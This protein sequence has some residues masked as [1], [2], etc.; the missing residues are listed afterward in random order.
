MNLSSRQGA[1]GPSVRG[2]RHLERGS[3]RSR[4]RLTIEGLEARTLLAIGS[5]VTGSPPTGVVMTGDAAADTLILSTSGGLLQHNTLTAPPGQGYLDNLSF[6]STNPRVSTHA[7]DG[8]PV[9]INGG[10]NDQITIGDATTPA[11]SFATTFT[12]VGLA[13]GHDALTIDDSADTT[14]RLITIAA[15]VD[16]VPGGADDRLLEHLD[17]DDPRRLRATKC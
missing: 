2:A 5:V 7:P 9:T 1:S 14:S 3:R 6:D 15:A 11:S 16:H 8:T 12:V 17:P 10:G 4:P 13:G